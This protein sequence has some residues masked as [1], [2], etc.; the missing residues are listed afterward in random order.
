MNISLTKAQECT[1]MLTSGGKCTDFLLIIQNF[2]AV[3]Y[4]HYQKRL[5][6]RL[7]FIAIITAVAVKLYSMICLCGY[8]W[9]SNRCSA[10]F[11]YFVPGRP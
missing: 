5:I 10:I 11:S 8:S 9:F 7:L 4:V 1:C 3:F 6:D 2:R